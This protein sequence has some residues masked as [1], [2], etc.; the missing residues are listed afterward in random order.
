M[1]NAV[2]WG[3]GKHLAWLRI[4][5]IGLLI[6]GIA[7]RWINLDRKVYWHDETLTSLRIF[8]YTQTELVNTAFDGDRLSADDLQR[9]QRLD[10]NR[11]WNDTLTALKGNAEHPPLYYLMARQWAEWFGSSVA[12]MRSLPALLSLLA[13]PL[14]YWLCLEWT[15]SSL[16]AWIG[17][18]LVA[19][20]PFHI[21]YA[22]E[23][24]EYSLWIVTILFSCAAFLRAF[25]LRTPTS[26]SLYA[27]SVVLTLYTH[28]LAVFVP[29]GHGLYLLAL[30]EGRSPK[31]WM[32]FL[33]AIATGFA[34][35]LPWI[36]VI[37]NNL[38]AIR[39]T[40]ASVREWMELTDLLGKWFLNLNR[41]FVDI[42]FASGNI[43]MVI[44]VVYIFSWLCRRTPPRLWLF[45]VMLLAATALP[46]VLPDLILGG[47]RS[48]L[49]RYLFPTYI[50]VQ[51]ATACYLAGQLTAPQIW[52]Y[53][54]GRTAIG[55]V[56]IAGIISGI[57]STQAEVWWTKSILRSSHY[58]AVAEI[59]NQAPHPLVISDSSQAIGTLAFSRYLSPDVSLQL[60]PATAVPT[61]PNG[62]SDV[63]LLN[64]TWTLHQTLRK[65][66]RY[67]AKQV[68]RTNE[69]V[70]SLWR[71]EKRLA[72][73]PIW[74]ATER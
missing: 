70:P 52:R 16:V 26:W 38:A 25:R 22:Q 19:V 44:A 6:V 42:E 49:L 54:V 50:G 59:I 58:T 37:F 63:F 72:P 5:V 36:V 20:S 73:F 60:I 21:L 40:T 57:L 11:S 41:V 62:F 30:K 27:L 39:A 4:L 67:E 71:L 64:D 9:Y 29:F 17:I 66:Q 68:Y 2:V 3:W 24:R 74:S 15:G 56:A 47:R 45:V 7:F 12:A 46:L 14:M 31:V 13:L 33:G 18:G 53:R 51:L 28:A 10:P 69:T 23:A 35:F 43:L 48:G 32:P 61:I 34:A 65:T 8:G 1:N 55:I